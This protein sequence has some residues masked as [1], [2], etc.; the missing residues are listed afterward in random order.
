MVPVSYQRNER[1]RTESS[2]ETYP[3]ETISLP[4]DIFP[5]YLYYLYYL[6]SGDS[7]S[8][9]AETSEAVSDGF[10]I[11]CGGV[12]RDMVRP[13]REGR[14]KSPRDLILST[15]PRGWIMERPPPHPERDPSSD[16]GD[17]ETIPTKGTEILFPDNIPL[18]SVLYTI[19]RRRF[20]LRPGSLHI[21]EGV[22]TDG[23]ETYPP[24]TISLPL[25]GFP[26]YLYYLYYLFSGDSLRFSLIR[27]R[28]IDETSRPRWFVYHTQ[29]KTERPRPLPIYYPPAYCTTHPPQLREDG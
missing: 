23:R 3:P 25:G 2:S 22:P 24:E 17:G 11:F 9:V 4:F 27:S 16:G 12:S 13:D 29:I 26:Y 10:R 15:A 20:S 14:G 21:S 28:S 5:Y 8:G 18:L 6:F 7:P 1:G 19:R